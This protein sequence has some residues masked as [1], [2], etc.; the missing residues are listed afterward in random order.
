MSEND[1][2]FEKQLKIMQDCSKPKKEEN[3]GGDVD[4]YVCVISEPKRQRAY[5][6]EC[7]DIIEALNMDFA[8]GTVFK[9]LWRSCAERALGLKKQGNNAVRDAEK[10]VYSSNRVLAIRRKKYDSV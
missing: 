2:E 4:Y 1:E 10:M 7:E 8:E 3:S 9:S 6:A 5:I